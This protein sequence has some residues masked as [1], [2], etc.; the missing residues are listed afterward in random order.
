MSGRLVIFGRCE[1]VCCGYGFW[2]SCVEKIGRRETGGWGFRWGGWSRV[3]GGGVG[4][5]FYGVRGEDGELDVSFG[6]VSGDSAGG[7][8]Y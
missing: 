8:F 2:F 4:R 6:F 7:E 1:G 5:V 3:D